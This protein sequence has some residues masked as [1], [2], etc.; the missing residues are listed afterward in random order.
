MLSKKLIQPSLMEVAE[1]E[2]DKRKWPQVAAG[3]V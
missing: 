3:E 2:K 1:K